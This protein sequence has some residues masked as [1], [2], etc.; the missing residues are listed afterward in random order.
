MSDE[1]N[2][3]TQISSEKHAVNKT[4]IKFFATRRLEPA[5]AHRCNPSVNINLWGRKDPGSV[6]SKGELFLLFLF[7]TARPRYMRTQVQ[8]PAVVNFLVF[9]SQL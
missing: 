7:S 6:P 2:Y 1:I 3:S 4:T 5:I 8:F 9:D